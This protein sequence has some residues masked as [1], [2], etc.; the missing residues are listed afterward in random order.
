MTRDILI[1]LVGALTLIASYAIKLI[2]FPEQIQKIR[3]SKST[4]GISKS[5]FVTSFISFVL[6]TVYGLLKEDWV[7]VLAQGLG[8]LVGGILLFYIWKYG[9]QKE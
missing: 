7:I 9:Q 1:Q 6:W 4:N 5:L 3:K 2:G 8:A